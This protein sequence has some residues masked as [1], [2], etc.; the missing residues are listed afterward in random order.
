M[1]HARQQSIGEEVAN[2]ISHGLALLLAVAAL[3]WLI[4]DAANATAVVGASVFGA[5]MITLYL[6]STLYHALPPGRAKRV[7]MTL[8]HSAIYLMIAGSYTPFMI[9]VL[10]GAWGWTLF[11]II[12][13]LAIAGIVLKAI[14]GSR[15]PAASLALYVAM[16][17]LAIVAVGPLADALPAD[18]FNWVIAGGIAYTLGVPFFATDTRMRFGHAA[19][20]G[21]VVAGSACHGAAVLA[22]A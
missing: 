21:C 15:F 3:P 14:L 16:G 5:S 22:V 9:G 6:A 1:P 17:W 2:S 11:G 7:F 8:D 12:W 13:T 4:V 10:G 18:A 20:H 19:W